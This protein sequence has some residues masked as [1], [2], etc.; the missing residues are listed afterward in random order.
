MTRQEIIAICKDHGEFYIH[1]EKLKTKGSTYLQ[2]TLDFD[3]KYIQE[4]LCKA[5]SAFRKEREDHI[6]VFS[7]TSDSFRYIPIAKIRR[8]TSLQLEL[9][10][11]SPLGKRR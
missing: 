2:G 9:D 1:Y 6:L 8:I 10:R 4:R 7:R 5:G 11:A 3:N